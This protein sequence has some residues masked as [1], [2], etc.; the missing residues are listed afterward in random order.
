MANGYE[1]GSGSCAAAHDGTDRFVIINEWFPSAA[2]IGRFPVAS[3]QASLADADG[4][5]VCKYAQMTGQTEASWVGIALTVA[6]DKI[7][8]SVQCLQ[9]IEHSRH[10]TKRQQSRHVRKAGRLS[11]HRRFD[12]IEV[13]KLQNCNSSAGYLVVVFKAD[14]CAGDILYISED[15]FPNNSIGQACLYGPRLRGGDIPRMQSVW[16]AQDQIR[17]GWSGT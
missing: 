10:L 11:D 14:V 13:R 12:F 17:G 6:E 16:Q 5:R 3:D 15:I 9:R 4:R 7:G 2:H 1:D 8:L